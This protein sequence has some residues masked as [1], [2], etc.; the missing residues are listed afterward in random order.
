MTDDSVALT[1]WLA[2]LA[3]IG[4]VIAA[5]IGRRGTRYAANLQAQQA[6]KEVQVSILTDFIETVLATAQAV[7]SYAFGM[8]TEQRRR[9]AP[10]EDWSAVQPLF[11]PALVAVHRAR[12]LSR[13]LIWDDIVA[14]YETCDEFFFKVI[15]GTDDD[16]EYDQWGAMLYA[17]TDPITVVIEL[18][19]NRRREVLATYG[20]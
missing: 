20:V 4:G 12:A 7:Q 9:R 11:E 5:E 13:S 15:R 3:V 17:E 2:V 14:A 10:A 8:S 18:A 19:G 16:A 6:G 1:I